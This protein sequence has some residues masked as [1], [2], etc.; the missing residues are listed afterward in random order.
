MSVIDRA[1]Q[2][3]DSHGSAIEK[4]R[5][6]FITDAALISTDEIAQLMN[7]PQNEDGGWIPFWGKDISS[8]DATCYKLAQLEQLGVQQHSM[9]DKAITFMLSKQ[10]DKGYFEEEERIADICPPWVK[11]G[12]LEAQLYLTANCALWIQYYAPQNKEQL[13]SA[14]EYLIS[15]INEGGFIN[16]YR[17][18]NWMAAGFLY[19][20][21]FEAESQ[22][23]MQ[24][25]ESTIEDLSSDNLAWL[26]NTL[27]LCKM[28]SKELLHKITTQLIQ[29]QQEDGSWSSDDG[30]WQ[31]MHT[32]LEA[33]RA[34]K[35]SE[36]IAN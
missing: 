9:I 12:E 27:I 20:M 35:F 30:E 22:R 13:V 8:L 25:I 1:I 6:K 33:L 18:T 28:N 29:L 10:A 3:I 21:G 11:P 19:R 2:Y 34:I 36:I 16:S 7:H 26:A 24:Y 23:M 4:A 15:H 5:L 14:A 31:R 17:H 32:T